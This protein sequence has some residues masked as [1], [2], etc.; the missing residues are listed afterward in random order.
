M[1]KK[2]INEVESILVH[3]LLALNAETGAYGIIMSPENVKEEII[4]PL[5]K[6][7]RT[8]EIKK[9]LNYL[10]NALR[11][12]DHRL[13]RYV[14]MDKENIRREII[15]P[16]IKIVHW[17][18]R[19]DKILNPIIDSFKETISGKTTADKSAKVKTFWKVGGITAAFIGAI[20]GIKHFKKNKNAKGK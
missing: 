13:Y 5:R 2:Q 7:E 17:D 16:L 15:P 20:I 11:A 19:N 8:G 1:D 4:K 14:L 6:F 10:E 3:I 12:G 9:I 18:H